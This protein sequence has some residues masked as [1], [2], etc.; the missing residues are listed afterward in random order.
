MLSDHSGLGPFGNPSLIHIFHVSSPRF[1][2]VVNAAGT[3][4]LDYL[5]ALRPWMGSSFVTLS[6]PLLRNIDSDGMAL[7]LL[8][9]ISFQCL[10][11]P[12]ILCCKCHMGI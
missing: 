1:D 11:F 3:D 12:L 4:D 10:I 8:K 2:L 6:P 9:V 7:G 5:D